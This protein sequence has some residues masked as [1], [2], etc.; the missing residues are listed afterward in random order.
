MTG[1]LHRWLRLVGHDGRAEVASAQSEQTR[2]PASDIETLT[3]D[4]LAR[5]TRFGAALL[6]AADRGLP[7]D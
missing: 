2:R 5:V 4:D 1:E 6:D 3:E 7:L